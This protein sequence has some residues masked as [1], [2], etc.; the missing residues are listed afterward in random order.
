[1]TEPKVVHST[2][3][4]ER[5]FPKLPETV[6]AAFADPAKL[7]RW[8]G[9]SPYNEVEEFALDFRVGGVQAFRYRLNEKTPVAG[10]VI[11]NE[12]R[13]Q[14]IQPNQ[15]IVTAST[16]DMNGKRV[17]ASMTTVEL[18]PN[19]TGTDVILTHQGAFFEGGPTPGMIE[20]GWQSLLGSLG[21]E[22]QRA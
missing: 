19:G 14:E 4:V 8:Y 22:L 3:V 20:E 16:M 15:R 13:F 7:R 2:F 17:N 6:F 1:M 18:L 21:K 9:E 5:S 12:G 10:T 11:R